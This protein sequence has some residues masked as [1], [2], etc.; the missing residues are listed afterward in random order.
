[1]K[2]ENVYKYIDTPFGKHHVQILSPQYP[3]SEIDL[4]FLH[5][6]LGS[7]A[8]WK[9]FPETL[10]SATNMRG[11]IIERIGHGRSEI[12][13]QDHDSNY[14]HREAL[15]ILPI[16]L[17]K[18][19]IVNPILIGHSDGAT[20]SLIFASRFAPAGLILISPHTFVE[21]QTLT[22]IKKMK[23]KQSNV[24]E[25]LTFF[26][27]DKSKSLFNSWH[28]IWLNKTFRTWNIFEELESIRCPILVIQG[29][30]DQYGTLDQIDAIQQKSNSTTF[31]KLLISHVGHSP[32]LESEQ[33]CLDSIVAFLLNST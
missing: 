24:I 33:L 18:L 29:E 27:G 12:K 8:Q 14:L 1:M 28:S 13:L 16:I 21:D 3:K 25:K 23:K 4:V 11:V 31:N 10:V 5:D 2:L 15:D 9:H 32:H 26:H 19:N 7:I 30:E 22:G 17:A 6:A 20:I